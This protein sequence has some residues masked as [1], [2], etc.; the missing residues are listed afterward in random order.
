MHVSAPCHRQKI[1]Y[2]FLKNQKVEI[3]QWPKK[4]SPDLNLIENLWKI[5]K[6]Y[7]HKSNRDLPNNLWI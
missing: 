7:S 1:V 3:L 5:L 6:I 4:K 2:E